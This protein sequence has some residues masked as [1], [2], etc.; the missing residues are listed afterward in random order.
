MSH[1]S[2][3]IMNNNDLEMV[4]DGAPA[5]LLMVDSLISQDPDSEEILAAGARLYTAYADVF[6]TDKTRSKK[7]AAKAMGY[8]LD[9]VCR[10][11]DHACG[12]KQMP[13]DQFKAVVEDMDRDG[14]P[15]L[16]GLGNAWA[17]WIMANKDDF[18][19]LA[20]IARIET[21]MQQVVTLDETYLDGAAYLY[22]GTLATF[23]PPALGGSLKR[24]GPILKRP[25]GFPRATTS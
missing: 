2:A 12:L 17:S 8:A 1:L 4:K 19:A 25:S 6:V 16:F 22:L 20:D 18:N 21:I 3:S 14:L 15:Y 9:A 13:F 24:A 7:L 11:E 23:L 5:Y 10:A